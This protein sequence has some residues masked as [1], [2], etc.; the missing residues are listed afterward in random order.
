M[1]WLLSDLEHVYLWQFILVKN[2]NG[3]QRHYF[4]FCS[5]GLEITAS[6]PGFVYQLDLI[7]S[8]VQ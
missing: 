1:K 8:S 5:K 2:S 6:S 7:S 4:D 3:L